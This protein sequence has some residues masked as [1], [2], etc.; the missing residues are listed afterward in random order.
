[1]GIETR[2]MQHVEIALKEKIETTRKGGFED[3]EFAHYS[4]PEI[5]FSD[6]DASVSFLKRKFSAP[7]MVV[8]MT[9]GFAE[10]EKI[11]KHFAIAAEKENIP[12]GLGSQRVMLEKPGMKK[13]FMVRDVAPKVFLAGNIGAVQLQNYS[14]KQIESLVSS[15]EANA[16][17]IHL[18]PLQ[19]AVQHEGDKNWGGALKQIEK[20]CDYLDVPV[21]AKETGAGIN[22]EVAKQ[23]EDAGVA[24]IDVSGVGGTSWSA[25]ELYRKDAKAG[26][27]FW[28]WGNAT[29]DCLLECSE[30]VKVP[31]IASG[32]IRSGLD[33]AKSIRLGATMAGAGLPFIKA[34]NSGG[35]EGIRKEIQLWKEELQIAMFLTRSKTLFD[36]K[37]AK[38]QDDCCCDEG[39]C[40]SGKECNDDEEC[41][42]GNGCK[43]NEDCCKGGKCCDDDCKDG[44]C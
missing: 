12:L 43:D 24:A 41:C 28:N 25:I 35:V 32:G 38:L 44:K 19:E 5:N 3:V 23:L 18:N 14:K 39:E 29:V 40:C 2:K 8:S 6:V 20:V 31:L 7:L 16:L 27:A 36:L 30:M 1:M 9:G 10:A 11:N 37:K 13:T 21:I 17:C 42:G 34:Q 22:G 33:V 15:I 26:A 4:L